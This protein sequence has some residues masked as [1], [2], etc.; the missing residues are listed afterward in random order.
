VAIETDIIHMHPSASGK[1]IG[2]TTF[3]VSRIFAAVV[4]QL[5]G[6]VYRVCP[7]VATLF[8]R[9]PAAAMAYGHPVTGA[10]EGATLE[11]VDDWENRALFEP[12]DN[13]AREARRSFLDWYAEVIEAWSSHGPR[14]GDDRS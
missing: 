13:A 1:A 12:G 7:R 6:G 2:Q 11:L 14:G 4:S 8:Q 10:K 3:T 9:G 5:S